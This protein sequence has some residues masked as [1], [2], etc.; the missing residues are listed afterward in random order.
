MPI[1]IITLFYARFFTA[2][3]GAFGFNFF[4]Q[5]GGAVFTA[6]EIRVFSTP[7]GGK[8]AAE[9]FCQDRLGE[10]VDAGQGAVD[11][12]FNGVGVGEELFDAADD[13]VL[14]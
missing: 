13:F 4:Q 3:G 12:L 9:G 14:F 6:D 5:G 7:L 11:L 10:A 2:A 1:T 8:L